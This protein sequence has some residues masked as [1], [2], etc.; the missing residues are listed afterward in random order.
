M[1]QTARSEKSRRLVNSGATFWFRL[2]RAGFRMMLRAARLLHH[3]ARAR[4]DLTCRANSSLV[5]NIVGLGFEKSVNFV[6]HRQR[7]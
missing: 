2:N 4:K 5:V 7:P 1:V 6:H 3:T